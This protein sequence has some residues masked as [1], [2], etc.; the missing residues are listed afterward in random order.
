MFWNRKILLLILSAGV[1]EP[2]PREL[3]GELLPPVH[4]HAP[5]PFNFGYEVSNAATGDTKSHQETLE[6]GV[7]RGSYSVVQPDGFRRVV[8]YVS[9]AEHGFR[10]DV[11]FEKGY[12]NVIPSIAQ[13]QA[14]VISAESTGSTSLSQ[15]SSSDSLS[16]KADSSSSANLDRSNSLSTGNSASSQGFVSTGFTSPL[17]QVSDVNNYG[18]AQIETTFDSSQSKSGVSQSTSGVSSIKD[19][20]VTN[21]VAESSLD[22]TN[23]N[24]ANEA[25]TDT[26]GPP[27][28]QPYE[29]YYNPNSQIFCASCNTGSFGTASFGSNFGSANSGAA[30]SESSSSGSSNSVSEFDIRSSNSVSSSL[31]SSSFESSSSGSTSLVSDNVISQ[32]SNAEIS[33]AGNSENTVAGPSG[34]TNFGDIFSRSFLVASENLD[35]INTVELAKAGFNTDKLF[36]YKLVRVPIVEEVTRE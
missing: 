22:T 7:L 8:N 14:S 10:A 31:G 5:V 21:N 26:F 1:V 17:I 24:S 4:A 6:D 36:A 3:Q 18:N 35:N 29:H 15:V 19:V 2:R 13:Q 23:L 20:S 32:N 9:D 33:F 28:H 12:E 30:S 16:T 34:V 25:S 27:Q 11:T